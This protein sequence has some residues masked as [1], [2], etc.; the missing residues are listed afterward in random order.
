ML[1]LLLADLL[2]VVLVAAML[3]G[4]LLAVCMLDGMTKKDGSMPGVHAGWHD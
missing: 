1:L 2:A 4:G 3:R